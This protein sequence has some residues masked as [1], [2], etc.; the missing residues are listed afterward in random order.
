MGFSDLNI[1]LIDIL[2]IGL[3]AFGAYRGY[4]NGAIVQALDLF[5]LILG[6]ILVV[7][8]TNRI[9][10]IFVVQNLSAAD[11]FAS[12]FLSGLFLAAMWI[13]HAVQVKTAQKLK[14]MKKTLSERLWGL[15]FGVLKYLLIAGVFMV[16][17]KE[18]D[19]YTD[20]L[21][22]GEKIAPE[23]GRYRSIMGTAAY[24]TITSIV[25]SLKF[26][27]NKPEAPIK[28]KKHKYIEPKSLDF[29]DDDF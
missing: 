10:F 1:H 6:F 26:E 27:T 15:F 14:G 4:M 19:I 24:Y 21:P 8:A 17:I 20:F 3:L 18:I 22:R 25:P 23:K 2:V 9:Y 29:N 13:S 12:L 11:L 16:T 28:R 5:T 7:Y